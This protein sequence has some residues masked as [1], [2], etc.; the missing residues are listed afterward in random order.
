M[1]YVLRKE[2]EMQVNSISNT[3]FGARIIPS[4]YLNKAIYLAKYDYESGT[5]E[6]K[7]RA[8]TFYNSL[9]TIELDNRTNELSIV[10]T[11]K[12]LPPILKLDGTKRLIESYKDCEHKIGNA[13]QE[14]INSLADSKYFRGE[15]KREEANKVNLEY[16]FDAWVK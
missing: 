7:K 11:D 13:V 3:T 5:P 9:R 14:A 16:A 4:E 8:V 6:G 10:D 15:M 1:M 12:K 2:K